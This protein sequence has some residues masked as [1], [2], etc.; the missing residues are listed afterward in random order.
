MSRSIESTA[1]MTLDAPLVEALAA[2]V[3]SLGNGEFVQQVINTLSLVCE[4]DSAGAMMLFRHQRPRQLLHRF[5]S[6]QRTVPEDAY[7][8]GPYVLDPHYQRFLEGCDSGAY[9]LADI[10]PD[11]FYESE[12]YRVFYSKTGVSDSIDVLWRIDADTGLVF[13]LERSARNRPF[14]KSTLAAVRLI[15]PAVF[16]IVARHHEFSD[17]PAAQA[18]DDLTHRK[19][20][21]TIEHF[22]S[23]LLTKREQQVLFYALSGYSSGLTAQ[24]LST[25]EGTV[26]IHR[27]NIYRKLEIGS[28]VELFSLFIQCIP[29]AKPGTNEDPLTVLESSRA[30]SPATIK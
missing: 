25:S 30:A 10:A 28:Q 9:W 8:K 1:S 20:Q 29:Y 24:R 18:D 19:V 3:H 6:S 12:Y 11:D 15:L 17:A 14:D 26:K 16:A 21:A 4:A 7:L 5:D 22:G 23:S 27:K 13:F 2:L